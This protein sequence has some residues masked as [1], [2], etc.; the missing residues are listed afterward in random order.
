M[1]RVVSLILMV[2]MLCGA[3]FALAE[4]AE[5]ADHIDFSIQFLYMDTS[6]D[7]ANDGLSEWVKEHF[8][9]GLDV[10]FIEQD[11][12]Q[13][14]MRQWI[15][16]GT[17]PDVA[18]W[19][20]FSMTEYMDYID[21]GLIAPLPD[22]W[23][24]KY[25]N[26][27]AMFEKTSL[28]DYLTVDGKVYAY[29]H[30]IYCNFVDVPAP[31]PSSGG[32]WYRKD[33]AE[34]LGF[35]FSDGTMTFDELHDFC[36]AAIDADLA[37]N[38][39]TQGITI[40]SNTTIWDLFMLHNGGFSFDSFHDDEENGTF[41]WNPDARK[42]DIAKQI[43]IMRQWYK[44]GVIDPDFYL[45]GSSEAL[46]K[47]TSGLSAFTQYGIHV[48]GFLR[49]KAAFEDANPD[50][51]FEDTVAPVLLI[52]E[53]G[54]SYFSEMSNYYTMGIFNPDIEP[55]KMDRI[56]A[57]SDYFCT[58]DG[59]VTCWCGPQDVDWHYD[60]MGEIVGGVEYP[61]SLMYCFMSIVSDDF[62]FG[63]PTYDKAIR[64][65]AL[66]ITRWMSENAKVGS[67][68]E[69]KYNFYTSDTK[70]MYSVDLYSEIVNLIM[71][72]EEILP[73]WESYIAQY[74]AMVD[75]LLDELNAKYYE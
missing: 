32:Y 5:F 34:Q 43:E 52:N 48:H 18:T 50:L 54:D 16:G 31:I 29:P 68:I 51:V 13:E 72:D 26:L 40:S 39:Q 53:D 14:T 3:T 35:D 4:E 42:E 33:W 30:A 24:E 22:G 66:S 71:N 25:P 28:L 17:L 67:P 19:E 74:D 7:Y 62:G 11:T 20:G 59:E 23:E 70:A 55:E 61:S 57:I 9:V 64:D 10:W 75:P 44:D 58:K 1:K 37:G 41:V 8:N 21:Q 49:V 56:L 47:F 63:N 73:A 12:N 45:T 15:A 27:Y 60:D 2:V 65:K 6:T 38:G 36:K 46:S 69:W